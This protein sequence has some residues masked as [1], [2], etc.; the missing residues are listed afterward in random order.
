MEITFKTIHFSK[1]SLKTAKTRGL[2]GRNLS[3]MS[4]NSKI[5]KTFFI[6]PR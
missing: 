6:P 1:T 3:T 4:K 5:P 2:G